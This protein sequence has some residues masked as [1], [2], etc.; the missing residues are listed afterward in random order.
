M[1]F[2]AKRRFGRRASL[3]TAIVDG[4][5]VLEVDGFVLAFR[6]HPRDGRY[7]RLVVRCVRCGRPLVARQLRIYTRTHLHKAVELAN[8]SPERCSACWFL[9]PLPPTET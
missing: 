1:W 6:D 5:R 4:N 8:E 9:A 7:F 3:T 2:T